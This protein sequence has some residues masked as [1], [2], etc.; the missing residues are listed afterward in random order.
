[1]NLEVGRGLGSLYHE[2]TGP[3]ITVMAGSEVEHQERPR[4]SETLLPDHRD[5]PKWIAGICSSIER[6]SDGAARAADR[7][8]GDGSAT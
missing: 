4:T 7:L 1:L 6:V 3:H 2:D 8:Q 5:G